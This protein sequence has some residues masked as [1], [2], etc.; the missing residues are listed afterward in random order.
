[1]NEWD[2]L[3]HQT[4][5]TLNLLCSSRIHPSFSAHASLFGNYDFNR[6]SIAPPGTKVVAHVSAES[7]TTFGQHG[8]VV[9]YIG[10][11]PEH[12]GCYKCYFPDTM[13]E[14]DVLTVNF[15]PEKNQ[16]PTFTPENYLKQTPEDMLHLL[17]APAPSSSPVPTLASFR[18]SHYQ[19][20]C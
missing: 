5:L 6:A 11:S 13:S 4:I 7:R 18:T 17:E 14:R 12:Y 2:R 3:I 10:P 8:Q 16:F 1:M 15:F 9:W 20:V 19:C